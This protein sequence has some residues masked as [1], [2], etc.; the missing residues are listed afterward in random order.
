MKILQTYDLDV[1]IIGAG[2]AGL[3]AAIKAREMGA[4]RVLVLERDFEA[5]GILNQCIHNGFGLQYFSEELT[6]PEYAGRFIRK[7]ARAGVEVQSDTM[8]LEV[9]ASRE[10]I[11]SSKKFGLQNFRAKS[12]ILA[13]GCRERTRDAIQIYGTRPAGIFT[14]GTA[15]RYTNIEGFLPGRQ[16]VVLGSGDIG[17]IMARRMKLE[18][19]QVQGVYELLPYTNGLSRNV[20]QCLNDFS[21]PLYLQQ[22]IARVHG[23]HRL[24]GITAVKVDKK[25]EPLFGTE[26]FVP[27]DTLLL[28]VGLIPENELSRKAGVKIDPRTGGPIVNQGRM[29]SIPGIFACGN[30]V[31]VHDLADDVTVE[32]EIAG[33]SAALFKPGKEV[34]EKEEIEAGKGLGYV[35]PQEIDLGEQRGE[36]L[37]LF[38]RAELPRQKVKITI[39]Q[40][41]KEKLAFPLPFIKPGEIIKLTIEPE[42]L[43]KLTPGKD[44]KVEVRGERKNG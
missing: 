37:L 13:M 27:C 43:K 22:T 17:L 3:G 7:A 20:V 23:D 11:T 40:E 35:V 9:K 10:V 39:S 15:Q 44:I 12:I 1:L 5:G 31:Q 8:V 2:P 4:R 29:T 32:S 19:C 26:E 38:M 42:D 6:G 30:V 36:P 41:E 25:G 21:I 14:A 34:E 24:E 28:S 33:I 16:V 18:G